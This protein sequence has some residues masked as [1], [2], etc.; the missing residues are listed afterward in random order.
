MSGCASGQKGNP[1]SWGEWTKDCQRTFTAQNRPGNVPADTEIPG[2]AKLDV[3]VSS[4][5][6][7][8]E[9]ILLTYVCS[10]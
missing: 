4:F 9:H 8:S 5:L 1:I 7:L 2:W 6:G 3:A 10:L